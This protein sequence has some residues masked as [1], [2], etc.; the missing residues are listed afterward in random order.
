MPFAVKSLVVIAG[1]AMTLVAGIVA[2]QDLETPVSPSPVGSGARAAGMADAFVAI[3]DDATAAS[4]NPAGLVQ[5]ESPEFSFV[6]SFNTVVEDF[7]SDGSHPEFPSS[8]NDDS[9]D[10]NFLSFVYPLP[11]LIAGRNAT[12]SLSYQQKFDLSRNFD[13]NFISSTD[14]FGSTFTDSKNFR[15]NQDGNLGSITPAFAIEVTHRL[16]VGLAV[17]LWR[18]NPIAKNE[19]RQTINTR[20]EISVNGV[21]VATIDGVSIE[22]YKNVEGENFVVGVLWNATEKLNIGLRYNTAFTADTD[23]TRIRMDSIG[24]VDNA[25]EKRRLRFPDTWTVGASYR[26]NDRLTLA[27]DTSITDWDDFTVETAAGET[28]SL[29]DASNV[30]DP[31]ERTNFKPTKTFRLGAEYVFLPKEP[32]DTLPRLWSLRGGL[33]YDEE[34]ASGRPSG[35]RSIEGDGKPDSFFGFTVGAGLLAFQR[36][37][38]DLAYQLRYGN[39]VNGDFVRG[40]PGFEEDIVQHRVLLSTVIYF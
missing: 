24:N 26:V 9:L 35:D 31:D 20:D 13:V 23:Y 3:A 1:L 7:L 2:A 14:I 18:D 29:V 16:S 21:L 10:V 39:G 36:V 27:F 25:A 34:P 38:I 30:N 28:F 40:V 4:W 19:F 6:G 12:L 33:F 5:L 15:F 22:E 32:E 8:H 37:N 11:F 17:N